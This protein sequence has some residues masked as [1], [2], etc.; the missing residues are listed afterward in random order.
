MIL[1]RKI[2]DTPNQV[3]QILHLNQQLNILNASAYRNSSRMC[4]DDS[5]ERYSLP[6]TVCGVSQKV[7]ILCEHNALKLCGPIQYQGVRHFMVVIIS[8][9]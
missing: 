9:G 1:Y 7:F 4:V 8:R 2:A 3:R 6:L 5:V